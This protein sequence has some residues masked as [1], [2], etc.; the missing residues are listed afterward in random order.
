M[1]DIRWKQRFDNFEKSFLQLEKAVKQ[2]KYSELEMAGIIQTY[3][4]TF[5]LA[6][7]VLQDLLKFNGFNDLVSPKKVL[8][9]AFNSEYIIDGEGWIEMLDK[10]NEMAHTYS[11]I[12]TEHV[13]ENIK[14]KYFNLIK[15]LYCKLK[16]EI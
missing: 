5:E 15:A 10:R 12:E 4:F 2:K 7:R 3:N 9:Q 8:Q 13:I 14:D 6:W 16:Q 1:A 11:S